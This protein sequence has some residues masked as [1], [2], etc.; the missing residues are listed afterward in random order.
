MGRQRM[1]SD[2]VLI[3]GKKAVT[4]YLPYD[5]YLSLMDNLEIDN[6]TISEFF[7]ES[8]CGYFNII[9][10]KE[11]VLNKI[12]ENGKRLREKVANR[13]KDL[14]SIHAESSKKQ[15]EDIKAERVAQEQRKSE[16][17]IKAEKEAQQKAEYEQS[18]YD[19]TRKFLIRFYRKYCIPLKQIELKKEK[20][21]ELNG[22]EQEVL[23]SDIKFELQNMH[24]LKEQ[25]DLKYERLIEIMNTITEDEV[26]EF[27]RIQKEETERHQRELEEAEDDSEEII[28]EE[29]AGV[30]A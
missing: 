4:I 22:D 7:I 19:N 16:E 27:M 5:V 10:E 3:N 18:I 15:I 29:Q 21:I 9:P 6:I 13:D 20:H 28:T 25:R 1:N 12:R 2:H 24:I 30:E 26:R 23:F 8:A 11:A 17:Q 14:I